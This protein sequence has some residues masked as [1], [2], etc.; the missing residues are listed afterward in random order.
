MKQIYQSIKKPRQPTCCEGGAWGRPTTVP[1]H[2]ISTHHEGWRRR[3]L[4]EGDADLIPSPELE[5]VSLTPL[6]ALLALVLMLVRLSPLPS[7]PSLLML[8]LLLLAA[9]LLASASACC[10]CCA[11]CTSS[12]CSLAPGHQLLPVERIMSSRNIKKTGLSSIIVC[13]HEPQQHKPPALC[14]C[15]SS[16]RSIPTL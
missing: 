16:T 6:L 8:L 3:W 1:S 11:C 5:A 7:P 9:L 10:N 13:K 12:S 15:N 14:H 2:P 4:E